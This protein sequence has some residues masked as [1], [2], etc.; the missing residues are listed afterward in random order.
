MIDP[1]YPDG[2]ETLEITSN[3]IVQLPVPQDLIAPPDY[4]PHWDEARTD[5][6]Y[7]ADRTSVGSGQVRQC[8]DSPAAFYAKYFGAAP[9]EP[10]EE[11]DVFRI[12]RLI[13]MAILE[14]DRFKKVYVVAPKFDRRTKVGKEG[15]ADF[16]LNMEPGT[17]LATAEE[18]EM[19]LGV[20]ESLMKHPQG[21]NLLKD[22][23]P[24]VAGYFRDNETGLRLRIKPDLLRIDGT[25]LSD[26]KSSRSSKSNRFGSQAFEYRYDIQIF[27][28]REGASII[29]GVA[30]DLCTSLV[31]EKT[32]PYEPAI[33]YWLKEDLAQAEYD[34]RN[35]LRKMRQCIDSGKWPFRQEKIE[36]VYTPQWF[37]F[38]S[39]NQ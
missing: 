36:R 3:E 7:H 35:G 17:I 39:V 14:H 12:G 25:S 18:L 15:H 13:H 16:M 29:N 10:E 21:P 19:I 37:I 23:K 38:N 1:E 4:E 28:Y 30:P 2:F 5:E 27:M 22:C 24:E 34:Y 6:Q 32:P 33:F 11:R 9:D 20:A 26:L 8:L 31:I